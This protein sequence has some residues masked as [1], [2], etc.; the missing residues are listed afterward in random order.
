MLLINR[1]A[2]IPSFSWVI[3]LTFQF[4]P[5]SFFLECQKTRDRVDSFF[6]SANERVWATAL[7]SASTKFMPWYQ[8][9]SISIF[10]ERIHSVREPFFKLWKQDLSYINEQRAH[11]EN[12]PHSVGRYNTFYFLFL[13]VLYCKY[14]T[15]AFNDR[16]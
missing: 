2:C 13:I 5:W 15:Q 16:N 4:F 7:V 8:A 3:S 10:F 12:Y 1:T 9:I 14:K 6:I 11:T